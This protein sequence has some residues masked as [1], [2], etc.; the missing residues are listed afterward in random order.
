MRR[1]GQQMALARVAVVLVSVIV[2]C[3]YTQV[4]AMEPRCEPLVKEG[5]EPDDYRAMFERWA[6]IALDDSV[7]ERTRATYICLRRSEIAN[8]AKGAMVWLERPAEVGVEDAIVQYAMMLI[9]TSG[10]HAD[11][12]FDYRSSSENAVKWL[13]PLV[14]AGNKDALFALG[15]LL[16]V[17]GSDYVSELL[18]I[19]LVRQAAMQSSLDARDL[20]PRLPKK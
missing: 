12:S 3:S 9:S 10:N 6:L 14:A 2:A 11:P 20:L 17:D 15:L 7:K 16:H 4:G 1:L 5:S 19:G 8:D 18:T 13:V